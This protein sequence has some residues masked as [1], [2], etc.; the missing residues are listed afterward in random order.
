MMMAVRVVNSCFVLRSATVFPLSAIRYR[1]YYFGTLPFRRYSKLGPLSP[2]LWS[3]QQFLSHDCRRTSCFH[4]LV[5]SVMEELES[6][7]RRKRV[8]ANVKVRLTSS[9]E[10]LEDKL[11]N[12]EVQKGLLLE[13]KKDSDR[14][15][16][17][18]AQR[19]DG[20]K[21]W[22]VFDQNGSTCSIKPQQITY[23]V[24]G[25]ENFDPREISSFLQRAQ[26]NLDPTLL[27]FAWVELLEKN[28]SITTEELAEIIFGTSDPLES[29]CA[30]LL[31]SKDELYFTVLETKGYRSIYGP[32]PI[33]QV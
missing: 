5:E 18:V 12:Q 6:S 4:R 31:L 28:K 16:L 2:V 22:M 13:F 29:Y 14:I 30:H 8:R 1:S 9:G 19:P 15:V 26:E 7:S 24:P 17:A 32:R 33:S 20:K 3:E 23:I 10:L 25:V 21:N 11:V 27:E